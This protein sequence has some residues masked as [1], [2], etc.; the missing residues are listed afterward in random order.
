MARE[1]GGGGVRTAMGEGEA[2]ENRYDGTET[3]DAW[4]GR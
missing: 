2:R 1:G 4:V 3:G